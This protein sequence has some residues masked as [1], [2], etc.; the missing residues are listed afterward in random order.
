VLGK[1]PVEMVYREF[2]EAQDQVDFASQ[3]NLLLH[4]QMSLLA[5]KGRRC[6]G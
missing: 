3:Q 2:Q 1:I 4:V 5:L 6:S